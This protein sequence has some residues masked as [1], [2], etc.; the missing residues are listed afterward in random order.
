MAAKEARASAQAELSSLQQQVAGVMSLV[1]KAT[2]E[3]IHRRTMQRDHS[4][5]LEDLRV[6]ANWALD[7][8]CEESVSRPHEDDDA[9]YL[10]F[11]TQI[12]TRLED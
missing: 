1:E 6:R 8:I 3:A 4:L 11:F 2:D 12:V 5:M 7:T 9:G 10:H